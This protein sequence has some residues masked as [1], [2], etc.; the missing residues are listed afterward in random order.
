MLIEVRERRQITTG[1]PAEWSGRVG[2]RM[3][4]CTEEMQTALAVLCYCL[5]GE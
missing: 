4:G 1:C 2:E 5:R 3:G